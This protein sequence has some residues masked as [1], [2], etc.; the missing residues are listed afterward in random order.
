MSIDLMLCRRGRGKNGMFLDEMSTLLSHTKINDYIV[1]ILNLMDAIVTVPILEEEGGAT[2]NSYI[3]DN[4]KLEIAIDQLQ[5]E[6]IPSENK[7]SCAGA[8]ALI[9]IKIN[10]FGNDDCVN[11]SIC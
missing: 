8:V 6:N 7:A 5:N 9:R 11:M 10:Q 2:Y 4:S 3:L 1:N